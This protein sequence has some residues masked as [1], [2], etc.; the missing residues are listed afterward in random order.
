[1][2]A[3]LGADL[4]CDFGKGL[5]AGGVIHMGQEADKPWGDF[6][7]LQS[8]TG[9]VDELRVWSVVRSDA[10]IKASYAKGIDVSS[11]PDAGSLAFYWRFDTAGL[12]Q[13]SSALDSSGNGL[14]GIVGG[15]QLVF[16]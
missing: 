14:N 11:D 13:G 15:M 12:V 5:Q 8:F 3:R 10:Q 16:K 7:E 9:L 4:A 2:R 6:E 1:M